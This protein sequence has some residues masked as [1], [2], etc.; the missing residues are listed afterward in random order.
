MRMRNLYFDQHAAH[1]TEAL[2]VVGNMLD[3]GHVLVLLKHT[4]LFQEQCLS[5]YAII[6]FLTNKLTLLRL[7]SEIRIG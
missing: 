6:L 1:N 7:I 3:R 2:S 4:L 5:L